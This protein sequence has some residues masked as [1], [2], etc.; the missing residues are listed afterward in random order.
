VPWAELL[1]R[2]FSVDALLCPRCGGPMMVLAFLTDL[3]VVTKILDHLSL[4]SASPA[5]TPARQQ[6]QQ[7][8]FEDDLPYA[9]E[10]A[11]DPEQSC[12]SRD[13]PGGGWA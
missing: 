3:D 1:R 5:L 13:P 11:W 7:E 8:L 9:E 4:P 2:V 12:A 6:D 10:E